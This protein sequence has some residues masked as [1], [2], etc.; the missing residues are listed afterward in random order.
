[1][2]RLFR[3]QPV[4]LFPVLPVL[5]V[6][7]LD[8]LEHPRHPVERGGRRVLLDVRRARL[9]AAAPLLMLVQI[10]LLP[11]YLL[12]LRDKSFAIRT[13]EEATFL[14]TVQRIVRGIQV[15]NDLFRRRP[16]R[17]EEEVDEQPFDR[18]PALR[19]RSGDREV[20]AR[21]QRS[22]PRAS[23]GGRRR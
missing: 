13:V 15:E 23:R 21:G 8:R 18:R 12:I 7:L 5:P 20:L 3:V 22:V 6:R 2:L 9:L 19:R 1:M 14:M 17:L 10:L 4:H 11:L 16:V